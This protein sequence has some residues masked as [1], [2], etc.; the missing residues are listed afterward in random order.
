MKNLIHFA[1][2]FVFIW[3]LQGCDPNEVGICSEENRPGIAITVL[4]EGGGYLN[5]SNI[6]V[7][8]VFGNDSTRLYSSYYQG[9]AFEGL[10]EQA[11]VY[12]IYTRL[13]GYKTDTTGPVI[14]TKNEC[15]VTTEYITVYMQQ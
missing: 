3:S 4:E 8:A 11:G 7:V 6:Q 13:P 9:N 2:G 15:H 5:T 1:L 12:T 14:V 10:Y